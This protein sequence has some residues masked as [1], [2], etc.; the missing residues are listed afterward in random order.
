M[1]RS[2]IWSK[3]TLERFIDQALL[4]NEEEQILRTR[5]AGW[6]IKQQAYKLQMSES[7]VS[8]IVARLKEKYD[9]IQKY[10]TM[11]PPRKVSKNEEYM[12]TH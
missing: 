8:K 2:I 9:S 10:D 11:L 1:T 12:D 7:K 4:T 3:T 6:T 5:V